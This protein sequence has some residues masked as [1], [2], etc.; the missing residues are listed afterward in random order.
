M[1]D[2]LRSLR[3]GRGDH[4]EVFAEFA[5]HLLFLVAGRMAERRETPRLRLVR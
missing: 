4:R 2:F 3:R 5:V 1:T